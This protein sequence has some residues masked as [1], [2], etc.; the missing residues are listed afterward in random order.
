MYLGCDVQAGRNR[1]GWTVD[2]GQLIDETSDPRPASPFRRPRASASR[3][4]ITSRSTSSLLGLRS[5]SFPQLNDRQ[6][7]LEESPG[8]KPTSITASWF[9]H[10]HQDI[11]YITIPSQ[12]AAATQRQARLDEL[13]HGQNI[14]LAARCRTELP[15]RPLHKN[16]RYRG[17]TDKNSST[18][19]SFRRVTCWGRRS[20][21]ASRARGGPSARPGS[22]SARSPVADLADHDHVGVLPQDRAQARRERQAR[23]CALP[24]SD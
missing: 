12:G 2:T 14:H 3:S 9:H 13:V 16:R 6:E 19:M 7:Q 4:R 17:A 11:R 10:G 21:G 18:P 5:P 1:R 23:S 24:G 15:R 22:R 20:C 8:P